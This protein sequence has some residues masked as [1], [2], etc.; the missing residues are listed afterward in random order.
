MH[1]TAR[2]TRH[3]PLH[4]LQKSQI[5]KYSKGDVIYE[6]TSTAQPRLYLVLSGRVQ[7]FHTDH[8]GQNV[9]LQ[10]VEP[11]GFFGE[12]GLW[13]AA[14]MIGQSAV[15]ATQCEIM[16]WAAQDVEAQI[17]REPALGLALIEELCSRC[18]TLRERIFALSVL[19]NRARL[20]VA[21]LQLADTIG[22]ETETG[23]IRLRGL[24]HQLIADYT[25]TSREIVT[26]ELNRL[27]RRAA[28]GYA[29]AY[30]DLYKDALAAEL[31]EEG[32]GSFC[33]R[34]A[35]VRLAVG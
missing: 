14:P 21:L 10:L 34:A 22:E 30:I 19:P 24:T 28:I 11:E 25:G 23:A 27:R 6:A 1:E 29:R 7:V 26:M 8:G 18:S 5:S 33:P 9:L 13:A 20:M 35:N 31:A 17:M 4:H 2:V 3:D 16:S 15:A 12:T 32:Q